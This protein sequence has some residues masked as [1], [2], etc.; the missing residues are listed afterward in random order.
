MTNRYRYSQDSEYDRNTRRGN[1]QAEQFE[2]ESNNQYGDDRYNSRQAR[3]DENWRGRQNGGRDDGLIH[4]DTS[5]REDYRPLDDYDRASFGS[6]SRY[7]ELGSTHSYFRPDDFGGEDYT[8]GSRGSYG[9][10]QSSRGYGFRGGSTAG[11]G[12]AAERDYA[13]DRYDSRRNYGDERG[14]FDR[15]SDEVASW[16]GDREAERRREMDHS[17]R[18]PANYERT[19]ERLLEDACER[20]THDPRVDARNINVTATESEITL[21]GTVDSRAA[22]RRAEDCVHDISGVKHVQN[23]LRIDDNWSMRDDQTEPRLES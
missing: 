20:L 10:G 19:P 16:F 14:F 4:S 12:G 3:R 22:K 8:R 6:Q 11:Y 21:D 7:E 5:Y 9:M 1:R 23:N 2:P 18:G 15:A 13:A 17:G